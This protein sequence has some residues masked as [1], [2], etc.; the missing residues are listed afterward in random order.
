MLF[1]SRSS[2]NARQIK[3]RPNRAMK[4]TSSGVTFSSAL[5]SILRSDP[6]VLMVGEVRD[7]DT[8]KLMLEAALT[9][10]SVF[11]TLHTN[12]A[13]SALTRLIDL[14][15][16]PYVIGSA[17]TAVLAQRLVRRLC[18]ECRERYEPSVSDLRQLGFTQDQID[19][20]VAFYRKRGCARCSNGYRGRIGVFQ[21]LVVDDE[22][23]G[24][25]ARRASGEELA[26]AAAASGTRTLWQDG[27]AKVAAGQT[28][29]DELNRVLR[30]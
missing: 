26:R 17:I 15:I 28:T 6:D 4:L 23:R 8:A 7:L 29:I 5:R 19:A 11:S 12:D 9:G 1:R 14:G 30:G 16:E 25:A 24:L 20:G 21:L 22:L 2:V 13:P 3:P 27:L 18:E 10:H